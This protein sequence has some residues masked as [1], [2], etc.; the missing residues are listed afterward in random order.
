MNAPPAWHSIRLECCRPTRPSPTSFPVGQAGCQGHPGVCRRPRGGAHQHLQQQP[1]AVEGLRQRA[2]QQLLRAPGGARRARA[3]AVWGV[4]SAPRDATSRAREQCHRSRTHRPHPPADS[5][6]PPPMG[7]PLYAR[8][9]TQTFNPQDGAKAVI[10]AASCD[11]DADR[12]QGK[13]KK[14]PP[15]QDLRCAQ[16]CV[17]VLVARGPAPRGLPA[18]KRAHQPC[19]T[20]L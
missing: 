8:L 15:A 3:G 11:W 20:S 4:W 19:R 17:R 16:L 13:G 14:L 9:P 6:P 12:P 18:P 1:Q 5:P 10:H 7:P 2:H